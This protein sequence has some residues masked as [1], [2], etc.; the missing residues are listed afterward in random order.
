MWARQRRTL[1]W[2][3]LAALAGLAAIRPGHAAWP[4]RFAREPA[5]DQALASAGRID[6]NTAGVAELERLPGIGRALAERI[7]AERQRGGRFGAPAELA[8][9]R[10]IGPRTVEAIQ[11]RLQ[12]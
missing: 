2:V 8:R 3:G 10:G 1:A 6:V 4:A 12:R 5:W 7:V 11:D 9:V